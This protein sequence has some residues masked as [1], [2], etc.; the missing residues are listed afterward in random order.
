VNKINLATLYGYGN[1]SVPPRS[2]ASFQI[3]KITTMFKQFDD[4]SMQ[5]GVAVHS[6]ILEDTRKNS[7]SAFPYILQSN[8]DEDKRDKP[9]ITLDFKDANQEQKIVI[10]LNNPCIFLVPDVVYE[11]KVS[12]FKTFLTC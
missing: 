11:L 9:Q 4:G 1:D 3:G 2:I 7:K 6:M 8:L 10:Y 5:V 12:H